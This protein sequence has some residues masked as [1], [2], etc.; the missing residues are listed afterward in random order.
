MFPEVREPDV[1]AV[2]HDPVMTVRPDV[3]GPNRPVAF[4]TGAEDPEPR[5][6][7]RRRAWR[8]TVA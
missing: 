5:S 6:E 1:G 2:E 7:L 4:V 3:R 8:G